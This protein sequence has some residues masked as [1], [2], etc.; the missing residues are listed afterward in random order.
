MFGPIVR[1]PARSVRVATFATVAAVALVSCSSGSD[2][3]SAANTTTT[4]E[5]AP[6]S[7]EVPSARIGEI[8]AAVSRWAEAETVG[9][10]ASAAEE[11]RNLGT[12]PGILAAGDLDGDGTASGLETPGLLPPADGMP[13][14]VSELEG[15]ALV[16]RDVLGGDWSDPAGRWDTLQQATETWSPTNN[17][18]PSLPSHPLRIVGWATLTLAS[19][20][21]DDA[22]EFAGHAQ[23]HVD[24]TRD[25]ID[26]CA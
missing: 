5:A 25:A 19:D 12:G 26:S 1:R 4:A 20:S 16:D 10:A 21:L 11:A 3:G 17:P 7:L 23:I 6:T 18:F 14:V 9:E 24:V 13:G 2:E 8:Q 15:C 22:H